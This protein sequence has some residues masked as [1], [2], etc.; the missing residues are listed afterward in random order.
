MPDRG[1]DAFEREVKPHLDALHRT[2]TRLMRDPASADDLLQETLLKAWRFFHSFEA[3]T[4]FK[5]WIFRVLYTSFVSMTRERR[6]E[7]VD[8]EAIGEIEG[9]ESLIE[10][11]SRPTHKERERAI[12]EAVDDRIKAAVDELPPDLRTVFLLSTIEGLKYREIAEVMDCPL[13]TVMSRLF[14]SRRL[15]QDRLAG[16]ARDNNFPSAAAKEA[17]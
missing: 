6:L 17:P 5:A 8:P 12:L 16:Y 4:N 11:I 15:L 14:R 2:A 3:G 1:V 9:R 7:S 13:G 10:E